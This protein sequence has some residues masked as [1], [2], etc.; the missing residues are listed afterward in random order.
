MGTASVRRGALPQFLQRGLLVLSLYPKCKPH[1]KSV[2]QTTRTKM[3]RR[4]GR[5]RDV[6]E[7][8]YE[9]WSGLAI[10]FAS[11]LHLVLL[12]GMVGMVRD[13]VESCQQEEIDRQLVKCAQLLDVK[14]E[15][16]GKQ[17]RD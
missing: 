8:T 13:R 4:P 10:Y 16:L 1:S 2:R 17:N 9:E 11:L 5:N 14:H 7:P 6:F 12:E 15:D 3:S